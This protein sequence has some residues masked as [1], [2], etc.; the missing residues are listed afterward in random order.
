MTTI[1]VAFI[2]S[3]LLVVSWVMLTVQPM[4]PALVAGVADMAAFALR[5]C[6]LTFIVIAAAAVVWVL[7][8][9]QYERDRQRDGAFP[10]REYHTEPWTRRVWN[11]FTG[12]PSPRVILD[13]NAMM[14]HAAMVYQGVHLA[15]PPAGWDRQL[16][17]MGD[18][19]RTRRVQAAI[20]GDSVLGNPFVNL[21]RGI[22]GVAN[23]A[24]GR[25]IAGAYD[26]QVKP[27]TIEQPSAPQLPAPAPVSV[28]LG[29][30][31][32]RTESQ[33]W[34]LGFAED[35]TLATFNPLWHS[36]AAIVGSPGTGKTTSAGYLLAAHALRQGWHVVILDADNGV[37]WSPFVQWAE[38]AE[39]DTDAFPTQ[40]AALR[41][42]LDR[43]MT[44]MREAGAT[45]IG[46][47]S[48]VRRMLVVMEEYGDLIATLRIRSRTT[49]DAIDTEL[50]TLLRRGRK[51]GMHFALID[52]YPENWSNQI[53]AGTKFRAV[54]Q[55]G[56]N[57]GAKVQEYKANELPPRGVFLWQ[58]KR[59][60]AW[61]AQPPL[62]QLLAEVPALDVRARVL[63][64]S[65]QPVH[66]AVHGP[67]QE[68][69]TGYSPEVAPP[70]SPAV[71]YAVNSI[72]T[73]VDGWYEWTL[74]NYLPA[75]LELLQTD[76]RGRGV[77]VKALAEAMAAE[78]GKDVDAMKGTASEVAK[79]LRNEVRTTT[80]DKLGVDITGGA[81]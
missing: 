75:H 53:I 30:A 16:S 2:A 44:L 24:T 49:A 64:V 55:L 25:M 74:D 60:T 21:Q 31:M 20:A 22:G 63:D 65:S 9:Q 11:T 54:F 40:L 13:V 29:D 6:L 19:E 72:P 33:A 15:E 1:K 52:Q 10:L 38:H 45:D 80:G 41:A 68:Q 23:A 37:A 50:D 76:D 61:H 34:P 12:K 32:S 7:L 28:S 70:P 69:F 79:R 62:R 47:V 36:H 4:I 73:T 67:V 56:P 59:Y 18:I 42:E 58:G 8:R 51:A 17:Y 66:R 78:C 14:T 81:A 48:G 46:N 57:Q 35:G 43:R 71:N 77:G 3:V 5:A 39:T 27:V 26:K